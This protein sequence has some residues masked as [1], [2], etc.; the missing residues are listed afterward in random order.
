M[1]PP[2]PDDP[3]T[4]KKKKVLDIPGWF[5]IFI[6][7]EK[8]TQRA[9]NTVKPGSFTVPRPDGPVPDKKPETNPGSTN[10]PKPKDG[11]EKKGT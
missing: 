5:T 9:K 2:N 3:P 6:P 11:P 7:E 8:P 4:R 1:T 10:P